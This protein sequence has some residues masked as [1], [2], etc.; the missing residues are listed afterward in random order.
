VKDFDRQW[1]RV[2]VALRD[3]KDIHKLSEFLDE[4]YKNIVVPNHSGDL[5]AIQAT[6]SVQ[7]RPIEESPPGTTEH[8]QTPHLASLWGGDL[9]VSAIPAIADE[10][11]DARTW[12]QIAIYAD[13]RSNI[14]SEITQCLPPEY[15]H[16]HLAHL[17]Y[18]VLHGAAEM[19]LL[20]HEPAD[21]RASDTHTCSRP[22]AAAPDGEI[23][24]AAGQPRV[25]INKNV[26]L[27]Q[28][29]PLTQHPLLR[30]RVRAQDQPGAFLN[31]MEAI[32]EFLEKE[33]PPITRENWSISYARVQVSTGQVADGHLIVRLHDTTQDR[34]RWNSSKTDQMA[35]E[36]SANAALLAA[37]R[38]KVGP[39]RN[40]DS[41]QGP[42]IRVNF[43]RKD[44]PDEPTRP[45]YRV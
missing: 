31:V 40:P 29:G 11:T 16:Y 27:R 9:D 15:Q 19:I 32:G 14:E 34:R 8:G 30:I 25:V 4:I 36:V 33:S 37:T 7:P 42:V 35:R 41:S 22:P 38:G 43:I 2:R 1:A 6:P 5:I 39:A 10:P 18:A 44:P 13:A 20:L 24:P 12:H 21:C 26:S 23:E 45:H 17:N 28:L 3:T